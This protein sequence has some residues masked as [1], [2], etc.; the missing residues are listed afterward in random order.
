MAEDPQSTYS[1]LVLDMAHSHD[2]DGERI[3]PGFATVEDAR[4]Y[5][6]AR[7]RASVEEL[8][9]RNAGTAELRTL[10]HLYGEDCI[11]IG[12]DYRGSASLDLYIETPA[13]AAELDWRALTPRLKRFRALLDVTDAEENSVW[14]GGIFYRYVRPNLATLEILFRQAAIEAFARKGHPDSVPASLH[15]V[16]LHELFDPPEPPIGKPLLRW[17]VDLHFVCHDI[18]YGAGESG[19]FVWPEQPSGDVLDRMARVLIGDGISIRGDSPE[20]ADYSEVLQIK[21]EA[22]DEEA[23]YPPWPDETPLP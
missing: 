9:G 13:D 14:A 20:N 7:T 15:V 10:W 16:K 18:K 1:V 5:A 22:T 2:P 8:R 11:V 12:G 19:V 17:R 6:E 3:V 4:R 21:V 23:D